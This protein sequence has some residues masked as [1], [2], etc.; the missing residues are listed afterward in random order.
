MLT[1][2]QAALGLLGVLLARRT[3]DDCLDLWIGKRVVKAGRM[4]AK[5]V[6]LGEGGRLVGQAASQRRSCPSCFM[7]R[8]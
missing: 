7:T 6:L 5:T 1:G 4:P 2:A 8:V 3:Q